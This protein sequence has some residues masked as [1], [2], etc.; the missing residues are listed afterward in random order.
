MCLRAQREASPAKGR[1][2]RQLEKAFAQESFISEL[3]DFRDKLK[4]AADF[5]NSFHERKRR[6]IGRN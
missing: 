6:S 3:N 1:E 5:W 4:R 2:A